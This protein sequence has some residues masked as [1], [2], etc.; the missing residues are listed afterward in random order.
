MSPIVAQV[1]PTELPSHPETGIRSAKDPGETSFPRLFEAAAKAEGKKPTGEVEKTEGGKADK[2]KGSLALKKPSLRHRVTASRSLELKTVMDLRVLKSSTEDA[3]MTIAAALAEVV[4]HDSPDLNGP[5]KTQDKPAREHSGDTTVKSFGGLEQAETLVGGLVDEPADPLESEPGKGDT[6]S[7]AAANRPGAPVLKNLSIA[8]RSD[9][10]GG[11][12]GSEGLD[13]PTVPAAN[14]SQAGASKLVVVDLRPER[15]G[16][17]PVEGAG[18]KNPAIE[19][20]GER[21]DQRADTE[22]Q[23]GQF[24]EDRNARMYQFSENQPLANTRG[25]T[26]GS[27]PGDLQTFS[28]RFRETMGSEIVKQAGIVLRSNDTGEIRMTL[29]PESL[30]SVRIRLQLADNQ[31]AGRI[32][33][34]SQAVKDVF[35]QNLDALNRALRDSGFQSAALDVAVGGRG[36]AG[37]KGQTEGELRGAG[38]RVLAAVESSVPTVYEISRNDGFV[39][40]VV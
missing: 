24:G 4:G 20:A 39:D 17:E 26:S 12:E 23:T 8:A 36:N 19:N 33:V 9:S 21:A 28:S 3:S 15:T 29:R 10:A 38:P 35:D 11:G 37:P 18:L 40:L 1:L 27:Q 5:L 7:A 14:R 16:A 30:G 6:T 34:D 32:I 13:G 2:L 31:I 25:G 22:S